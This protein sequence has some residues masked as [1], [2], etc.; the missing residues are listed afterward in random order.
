[1]AYMPPETDRRPANT[2]FMIPRTP[3]DLKARRLASARWAQATNGFSAAGQIT[4]RL[5]GRLR[6][7]ARG[8]FAHGPARRQRRRLLPLGARRRPVRHVRDH[9][10]PGRPHPNRPRAVRRVH[11]G[12]R[13]RGEGRRHRRARLSEAGTGAAISD[14]LFV[15]C[16]VPQKPGDEDYALSFAVPIATPGLKLYPRRPYAAGAERQLR[17]PVVDALRRERRVGR[18]RRRLRALGARVRL[19]RRRD[20]PQSVLPDRPTC[21]ATPRP[22]CG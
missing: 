7:R 2:A 5:S 15:S 6:Q 8:V 22:R 19:S 16:M 11:A 13:R 9:P 21:W 17:L 10:A 12:R 14:E 3:E 1:M 4:C 18:L 20:D